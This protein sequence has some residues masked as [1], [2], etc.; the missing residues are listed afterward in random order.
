MAKPEVT[1]HRHSV[2]FFLQN[3]VSTLIF[4]KTIIPLALVGS[5]SEPTR[6]YEPRWLSTISYPTRP[7]YA[8]Y[9]RAS[10]KSDLVL[11]EKRIFR[12]TFRKF[13]SRRDIKD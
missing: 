11:F 5:V 3:K 2:A 4:I 8:H 9:F 12:T 6:R 13:V 1:V 7:K 10:R